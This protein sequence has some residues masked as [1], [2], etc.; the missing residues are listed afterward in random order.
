MVTF[1]KTIF[2]FLFSLFTL[3]LLAAVSASNVSSVKQYHHQ[4]AGYTIDYPN[5]W[6]VEEEKEKGT[7]IFSGPKDTPTYYSTVT[8]QPL[9]TTKSKG[10]YTNIDAVIEDIKRQTA[11]ISPNATFL[12]KG[13]VELV[14]STGKKMDGK[15]LTF[16]YAFE[17][18]IVQQWQVVVMRY[19]GKLIYAWA[20]TAPIDQYHDDLDTARTMFK[21]WVID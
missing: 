21:S 8:I 2:L 1:K 7:V 14:S 4:E 3:L 10:D 16:I 6:I 18:H 5:K 15:F 13:K 17:G 9:L 12:D 20:Y 19:D 11:K